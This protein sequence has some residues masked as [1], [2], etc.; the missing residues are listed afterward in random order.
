[1]AGCKS[2]STT[3]SSN[4]PPAAVPTTG[5][6]SAPASTAAS[7]APSAATGGGSDPGAGVLSTAHMRVA[8][9]LTINGKPGPG[10]DIYDVNL[11]GQAATPILTNV[12]YGSVSDYAQLH[13][14]P[15]AINK[16]VEFFALPTG[17]DPVAQK[18][19]M[20]GIG[21]VL[22]DGSGA[23]F[24]DLL[25]GV[26]DP[27]PGAGS[28]LIGQVSDSIRMEKGDDGQGGKGPAAPP[29]TDGSAELL[30][31]TTAVPLKLSLGA[32]LMIDKL[33]AP[34]LNGDPHVKGIPYVFAAD[35]VPPVSSYAVFAAP[36]GTH[37]ISVVSWSSSTQPSC[38]Q[39]TKLQATTSV[40]VAANQQTF[41]FIYGTS[42]DALH[43][44][45]A[46]IQ[47]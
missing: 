38:K 47:P 37:Q 7:A 8:N 31:D 10:L 15:N 44:V 32:Y 30:A 35:G 40:T 9:F 25:T 26:D 12:A 11:Q 21:G 28:S 39:L 29:I 43:I 4:P 6:A 16:A 19:D 20:V 23:Q 17:E 2:N 34:P 33:C 36:V 42:T 14:I 13:Q 45:T 27:P 22:D 1:M 18:G 5:A 24:T 3:S 41:V 46:P